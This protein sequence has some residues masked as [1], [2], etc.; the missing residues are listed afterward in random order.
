[1]ED[2]CRR[3]WRTIKH[4]GYWHIPHTILL[5]SIVLY[6]PLMYRQQQQPAEQSTIEPSHG[7][8]TTVPSH[9]GVLEVKPTGE[10]SFNPGTGTLFSLEQ[11]LVHRQLYARLATD[12]HEIH[13]GTQKLFLRET[14]RLILHRDY[15]RQS[16]YKL[17]RYVQR[18]RFSL[19]DIVLPN[20]TSS[21]AVL[22]DANIS[23][24]GTLLSEYKKRLV[25]VE[26]MLVETWKAGVGHRSK[27]ELQ[28][29][30]SLV[31]EVRAAKN[32]SETRKSYY[33]ESLMMV[34]FEPEHWCNYLKCRH[35]YM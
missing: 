7:G 31:D 1:M 9:G 4:L 28:E 21:N 23:N 20:I 27:E 29:I 19:T 18:N 14:S 10:A 30:S 11:S 6:W 24:P 12:M 15:C 34:D 5:V 33:V 13:E 25:V 22:S 26:A 8:A 35:R 17:P 2:S 3:A 16:T 32:L